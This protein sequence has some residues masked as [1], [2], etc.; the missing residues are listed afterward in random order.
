MKSKLKP[1]RYVVAN[2]KMNPESPES[3]RAIFLAT[4][5]STLKLKRTQAIVCPPAI[6]FGTLAKLADA[7]TAIGVQNVF[8]E[9][10][11]PYTGE[12]NAS[13]VLAAGGTHSIVGHSER[14]E[15]GETNE[16][17]N[18]KVLA[19]LEQEL[20]VILCIGEK[21]RDSQGNYL[22]FV[23]EQLNSALAGIQKKFIDNLFI[24][25]EPVWAIGKKDTEAMR[26]ADMYEMLLYIRKILTEMLGREYADTIPVLYGGS[27]SSINTE[28]LIANG[29]VDGL[30]VGRQSLDPV[31]FKGILSI[32]DSVA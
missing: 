29:H 27:V 16:I 9:P 30:L 3:A 25:Y 26:G 28:D 4:R 24:A 12:M 31:Q 32:V 23:K 7:K 18:K 2:W 6:Y 1:K 20:S 10:N 14:R 15:L 11:G 21:E 19:A 22:A 5:R 13:M 17:V 8:Y